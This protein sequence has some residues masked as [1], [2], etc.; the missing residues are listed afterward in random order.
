MLSKDLTIKRLQPVDIDDIISLYVAR[1]KFMAIKRDEDIDRRIINVLKTEIHWNGCAFVG[2]YVNDELAGFL[3]VQTWPEDNTHY[4]IGLVISNPTI[5]SERNPECRFWPL[6]MVDLLNH[7]IQGMEAIHRTT[8]YIHEP[9]LDN[10]WISIAQHPDAISKGYN[11]TEV[12]S[13]PAWS[14][15]R[16]PERLWPVFHERTSGDSRIVEFATPTPKPWPASFAT[17]QDFVAR[18]P[19]AVFEDTSDNI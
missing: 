8:F 7:A 9:V 11:R 1:P 17:N 10:N 2:G 13:L 16:V 3:Q 6:H 15:T 14:D 12:L 5:V 19:T 18:N 4:S